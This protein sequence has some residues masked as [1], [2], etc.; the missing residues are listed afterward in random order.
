LTAAAACIFMVTSLVLAIFSTQHLGGSIIL[1]SP[2]PKP[3]PA[4]AAT[5]T[6]QTTPGG[7][8]APAGGETAPAH[9][10]GA[11]PTQQAK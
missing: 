1:N 11:E 4:P 10:G 7:S 6:E 5:S 3:A 2:V 9:G 8:S